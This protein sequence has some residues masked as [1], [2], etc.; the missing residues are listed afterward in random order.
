MDLEPFQPQYVRLQSVPSVLKHTAMPHE[1]LLFLLTIYNSEVNSEE[2]EEDDEGP[3]GNTN[4][5]D[6]D[7][8]QDQYQFPSCNK[9]N[10]CKG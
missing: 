2:E 6:G 8:L 4:W 3:I 5:V 7:W 1:E 10:S 9:E